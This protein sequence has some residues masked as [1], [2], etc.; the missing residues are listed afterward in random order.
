MRWVSNLPAQDQLPFRLL[1]EEP[2]FKQ[3][4]SYFRS[5]DYLTILGVGVGVPLA[6]LAHEK[7]RP[8]VHPKYIPRVMMI[9]IPCF[10]FG[11]F[12]LAYQNS[13]CTTN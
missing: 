2:K 1:T 10:L 9:Q 12:L 3:V 4:V 8:S 11:G 6:L 7:T 5:S 13:I